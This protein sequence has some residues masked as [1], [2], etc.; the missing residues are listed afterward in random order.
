MADRHLCEK[1]GEQGYDNLF[2]DVVPAPVVGYASVT[3]EAETELKRGSVLNAEG[4]LYGG[5]GSEDSLVLGVVCEDVTIAANATANVTV[6]K[7]GTFNGSAL[8]LADGAELVAST[9]AVLGMFDIYVK[10]A[11]ESD[12]IPG[13]GSGSVNGNAGRIG[14]SIT[15][16]GP[17]GNRA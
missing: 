15:P 17:G 2:A 11:L 9:I 14:D 5:G 10:F 16:I 6:Y 13:I 4:G 12:H 3:A 7:C 8:I 1:I